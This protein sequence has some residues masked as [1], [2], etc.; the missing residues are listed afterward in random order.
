M[1]CCSQ[2]PW[3]PDPPS[4]ASPV[5]GIQKPWHCVFFLLPVCGVLLS[6]PLAA[7]C[8]EALSSLCSI[9][10]LPMAF[11][12]SPHSRIWIN[13]TWI[14]ISV[15]LHTRMKGPGGQ[16]LL[17]FRSQLGGP[18]KFWPKCVF[19]KPFPECYCLVCV[20]KATE[21]CA[22]H[23][24]REWDELV[25]LTELEAPSLAPSVLSVNQTSI[26]TSSCC[27]NILW[28]RGWGLGRIALSVLELIM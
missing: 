24:P 20:A 5:L 13:C 17:C 14:S 21:C 18:K 9:P 4:S 28:G 15:C 10:G 26:Q 1:P 22:D 16:E 25:M 7:P 19:N 6:V 8:H 11:L 2:G 12:S 23:S 3:T 27:P